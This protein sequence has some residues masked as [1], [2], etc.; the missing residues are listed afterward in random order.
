MNDSKKKILIISIVCIIVLSIGIAYAVIINAGFG[1]NNQLVTGDIY[2]HYLEGQE[3]VI[4]STSGSGYNPNN[5]FQ[6]TVEGKNTN[7]VYDVIYDIVLQRG[8]VPTG[9]TEANRI[10]DKLI[11]F[12]LTET[13][14]QG[15]E[16]VIFNDESWQG[17][18]T[19][20]RVHVDRIIKNQ[21][22]ETV[23]TYKLYM[24]IDQDITLGEGKDYTYSEWN[25]LFASIKVNVSGDFIEKQLDPPY[26]TI[27]VMNTFPD[28]IKSVS[29]SIKK[30][31]FN[32]MSA[33]AMQTA[34]DAATIKADI[35]YNN[36][37]RVL[38]YLETNTQ[39]NTKYDLYIVS[40]GLTYLTTGYNLFNGFYEESIEFNNINTSRVT[41]MSNMFYANRNLTSIDVSKFDTS[42]VTSMSH[43]FYDCDSLVSL[44]LTSLD[45]SNVENM[46]YLAGHT[47]LLEE[48][49][50]SGL[51]LRKV[52]DM[53]AM[54]H[55][56]SNLMSVDFT[57]A[58]TRDVTTM[59]QMFNWCP[60]IATIDLSGLG[61]DN[62]TDMSGMFA[63]S[64]NVNMSINMSDFNFG[65]VN[66][67]SN[68]P[69][70]GRAYIV[71]INLSNANTSNVTNM[72]NMFQSCSSLTSINLSGIGSSTLQSIDNIFSGCTNLA[73]INM[74]NFNLG[75]VTSL[76][77]MFNGLSN[78]V[79]VNLSGVDTSSVIFMSSMFNGCSSL[80]T[81]DLSSF[82]L[83]SLNTSGGVYNMF[84]G[85]TSLKTIYVSNDFDLSTQPQGMP[86]FTGCTSLK[87]GGTPQTVY[88]AS[89]VDKEYARIDGGAN[90]VT[91]GY[92][93]LKSN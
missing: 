58:K 53:S 28:T 38:A 4:S 3:L 35:T 12:K 62:L 7:T 57:G 78:L 34:Y 83:T 70:N 75:M 32:K 20:K 55:S 50:L 21:T 67:S 31:Y 86:I 60:N 25:N 89:H 13:K 41:D 90:S 66:F 18:D 91:P 77:G 63:S 9:K 43:M 30:I 11:R 82:N 24:R 49:D 14:D 87:G 84:N 56:D 85:M 61:G 17:L 2:M 15:N 52:Q 76:S 5:Y 37:R 36:E 26:N 69:F 44:D 71:S 16:V 81:L 40:D 8:S 93:T 45:T 80:E 46:T 6:F 68:G 54:F 10:D 39:D 88:D 73:N 1:E 65:K 92:F 42:N 79:N 33:S 59:N 51:D 72:N 19:G 23:H 74:S 64:M 27:N 47:A 22:T 29:S 48:V